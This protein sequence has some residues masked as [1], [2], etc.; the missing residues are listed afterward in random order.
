VVSHRLTV[1]RLLS[2][3][4]KYDEA[5]LEGNRA[6]AAARSAE[7]RAVAQ[8]FLATLVRPTPPP[9]PLVSPTA[10]PAGE[11]ARAPAPESA[12]KPVRI[13][14]RPGLN[15]ADTVTTK[16]VIRSMA[17]NPTGEL[18]F[19]VETA[20]AGRLRLRVGS[21]DQ[22][23][24]RRNGAYVQMDWTCGALGIPA[25]VTYRP[26]KDGGAGADGIAVSFEID[27]PS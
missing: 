23:M 10:S 25:R 1:G 19:V 12:A 4:G 3:M 8:Q 13:A 24:L 17:C 11:A 18:L 16:G 20:A 26:G 22:I 5:S 2:A 14:D 9:P 15:A 21:P 7:D 27:S 6:L